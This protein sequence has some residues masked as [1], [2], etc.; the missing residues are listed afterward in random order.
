[1]SCALKL[2]AVYGAI[3]LYWWA[4]G[5]AVNALFPGGVP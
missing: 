1:M 3:L 4:L 2:A 5:L